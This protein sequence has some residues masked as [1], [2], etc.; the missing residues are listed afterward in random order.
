MPCGAVP[1]VVERGG[2][3]MCTCERALELIS[4]GLDGEWKE[5]ERQE[6]E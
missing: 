5:E 4:M 6:L 2:S 1:N 3:R